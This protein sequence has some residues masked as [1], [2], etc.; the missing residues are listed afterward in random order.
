MRRRVRGTSGLPDW[1][2][3]RTAMVRKGGSRY[4]HTGIPARIPHRRGKCRAQPALRGGMLLQTDRFGLGEWWVRRR[5]V[6]GSP[7]RSGVASRFRGKPGQ[8]DFSPC[9]FTENNPCLDLSSQTRSRQK[10]MAFSRS[11]LSLLG[12]AQA[13]A[14][15]PPRSWRAARG[16]AWYL[17]PCSPRS[18]HGELHNA[19]T[20][21]PDLHLSLVWSS[22]LGLWCSARSASPA[23]PREHDPLETRYDLPPEH[24]RT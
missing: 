24:A 11:S 20:P 4:G 6:G 14:R 22:C 5:M 17:P 18:R 19:P 2:S 10:R 13:A 15:S 8:C 7:A 1:Y 3:A 21:S 9:N 23:L 16:S 12:G